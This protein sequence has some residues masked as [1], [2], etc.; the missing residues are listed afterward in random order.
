MLTENAEIVRNRIREV[1]SRCGR[2]PEDVL[3]L[4]V[5]K[6]FGID[7]ISEAIN[8]GLFDF[9]ENY[10]QEF[11]EKCSQVNDERVR[12]HFIGHLQSNKV[13]Y[14]ADHV[15]LIHSLDN[16]RLAEELQK[17]AEKSGRPFDVLV[18]VH[19]TD[20]ATKFG[21]PPRETLD[22]VK[23]I[24][25]FGH[26]RVQGL[27]TMG[28]FSDDPGDSRPSFQ[29]LRELR[30]RIG[31]EGIENVSMRHLS[32]GMTHDYEVAIEEGSTIVRI[33]TAIF[34]E[35]TYAV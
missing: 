28:P 11:V 15:H 17:R 14:I 2:K 33:G 23:R 25:R 10:A 12:W 32:M 6:T 7:R 9:G 22:L 19:T 20:E 16:D 34:G 8:A 26:V 31:R 3:L 27:M 24:A 4:A 35:R 29:Q 13:K 18:E 30:D 5:S 1:C 21:I